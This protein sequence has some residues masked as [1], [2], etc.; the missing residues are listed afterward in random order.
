MPRQARNEING[1]LLADKGQ[2]WTSFDVVNCVK[3][4]F[5]P[6]KIGHCG[7]LDPLATGLL[8]ILLGKATKLQDRFMGES[9]VYEGSLRLG[10]ETDSEDITGSIISQ[11]DPSTVTQESLAS[12]ISSMTG[13][14]M[15]IPPMVSALKKNGKPLYE[16][17][18]Q[19]ITIEREARQ[20]TV[21]SFELISCD[22]PDASFRVHCTRGTYV[23]TLCAD[24][25][26][27]LGCG[28]VMTALR[29]VCCGTFNVSDAYGIDAIKS[30]ELPDLQAHVIPIEK[31]L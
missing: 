2:D 9:K 22:L 12:V 18:R 3:H 10:I 15:Q 17:A 31:F 29:R 13:P 6:T 4:R 21:H 28:A 16:L 19:G 20:I 25:G 24:I 8:V 7:T 23:R 5:F 1:V 30:W 27:K 14:Q 11:H 26:K